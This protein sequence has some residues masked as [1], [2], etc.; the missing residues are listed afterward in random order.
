MI[1]LMK[2][3]INFSNLYALIGGMPEFAAR[4]AATKDIVAFSRTFNQILNGYKNDDEKYAET[5]KQLQ[6]ILY[7][8]EVG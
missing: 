4:F 1:Q 6:I 8:L 3:I 7:I 5:I 2:A